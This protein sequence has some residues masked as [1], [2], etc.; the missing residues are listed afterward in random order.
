MINSI[1]LPLQCLI[2]KQ[3]NREWYYCVG[4]SI[5]KSSLLK[6]E[7]VFLST[8]K[9]VS[10]SWLFPIGKLQKTLS[11]MFV[12]WYFW[13]GKKKKVVDFCCHKVGSWQGPDETKN[14]NLHLHVYYVWYVY[15]DIH[16]SVRPSFHVHVVCILCMYAGYVSIFVYCAK[17]LCIPCICKIYIFVHL[18]VRLSVRPSLRASMCA[19]CILCMNT[20]CI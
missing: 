3:S 7:K 12:F 1:A 20:V 6:F 14:I 17:K 13:L 18:P 10:V 4:R 2:E 11:I 5:P 15:Y 19:Y 9:N 8:A 16:L